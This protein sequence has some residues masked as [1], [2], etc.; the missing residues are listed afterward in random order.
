PVQDWQHDVRFNGEPA[1]RSR[2]QVAHTGNSQRLCNQQASTVWATDMFDHR[3]AH[4]V[5]EGG[6]GKRKLA[7]VVADRWPTPELSFVGFVD[8]AGDLGVLQE[9]DLDCGLCADA[10]SRGSS[11]QENAGSRSYVVANQCNL[12][13]S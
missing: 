6:I 4:H 8:E 3:I 2:V 7:R 9:T 11:D 5:V 13:G 10:F 12:L 1:I